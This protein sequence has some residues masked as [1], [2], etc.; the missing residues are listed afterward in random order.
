MDR[1]TALQ[2]TGV[3]V[4]TVLA[5]LPFALQVGEWLAG[6]PGQVP[7][8]PVPASSGLDPAA[9][10]DDE[11]AQEEPRG[12]GP[13]RGE[14]GD[15]PAPSPAVQPAENEP[16]RGGP[17]EAA[18][19]EEVEEPNQPAPEPTGEPEEPPVDPP[20][21]PP[22]EPGPTAPVATGAPQASAPVTAG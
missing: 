8:P 10:Q 13:G 21:E 17:V 7:P 20:D 4:V 3:F 12:P 16:V 5:G 1:R 19:V 2:A 11:V 6:G 18:P 22:A 9:D 15:R 14:A